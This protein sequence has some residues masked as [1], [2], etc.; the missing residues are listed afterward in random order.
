MLKDFVAGAGA[1]PWAV[2]SM[3]FFILVF[4]GV[5]LRVWS[6]TP[7]EGAARAHLPLDEDAEPRSDLRDGGANGRI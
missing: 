3:I 6:M 1:A 5:I 2:V 7:E 4:I